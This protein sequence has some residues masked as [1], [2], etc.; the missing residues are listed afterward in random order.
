MH[1]ISHTSFLFNKGNLFNVRA[2]KLSLE[3]GDL[4][5]DESRPSGRSLRH[6]SKS[7]RSFSPPRMS[8][9][10]SKRFLSRKTL[11]AIKSSMKSMKSTKKTS[12]TKSLDVN[13]LQALT[14]RKDEYVD[15]LGL[16]ARSIVCN[17][18][19]HRFHLDAIDC[20]KF[21]GTPIAMS[22]FPRLLRLFPRWSILPKCSFRCSDFLSM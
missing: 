21:Q 2:Y 8:K 12:G 6:K 1:R 3:G 16:I 10:R 5:G 4:G 19:L 13:R 9:E 22:L 15:T 20:C 7:K 18:H 11:M 14:A 17:S